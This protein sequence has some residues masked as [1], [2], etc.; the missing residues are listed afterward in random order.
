MSMYKLNTIATKMLNLASTV[1]YNVEGTSTTDHLRQANTGIENLLG[2]AIGYALPLPPGVDASPKN[3]FANN[4][5]M[6]VTML[7]SAIGEQ[8]ILNP[9]IMA[10]TINNTWL[11]RYAQAHDVGMLQRMGLLEGCR[12]AGLDSIG[13]YCPNYDLGRSAM[14]FMA[15]EQIGKLATEL[16]SDV[17]NTASGDGSVSS[18]DTS[19]TE[20]IP[21]A[22][23]VED[24][25][26]A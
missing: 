21:A 18:V 17:Q 1:R 10:L 2:S 22:P 23:S 11:Y 20:D 13:C 9:E 25:T 6:T 5:G 12:V 7:I 3:F 19:T 26:H 16:L 14:L 15:M 24:T 4:F 8:R